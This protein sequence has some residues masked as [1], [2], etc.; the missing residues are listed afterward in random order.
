MERRRMRAITFSSIAVLAT[1]FAGAWSLTH[2]TGRTLANPAA[3]EPAMN[4]S[5]MMKNA[6]EMPVHVIVDAI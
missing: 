1:I 5:E 6:P 2:T 4:P 3:A